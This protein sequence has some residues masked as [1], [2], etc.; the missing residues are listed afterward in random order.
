M[1]SKRQYWLVKSEPE[2]WSWQDQ[3]D[4]GDVGEVWSGVRNHQAANNLKAMKCG[5]R[6]LF[7]HSGKRREIVGITEVIAEAYP[8]PTDESGKFVAV[9]LKAI[10]S[11]AEPLTLADIK[12]DA[13]LSEMPLIR[14]PRLSV[15][16]I[17]ASFWRI[18]M[19][20]IR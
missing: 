11:L 6:V 8:D 7:Y 14:Q 18:L 9:T 10:K 15:M 17:E 16:P 4:R 20:K 19:E 12:S 5:D 13:R 1:P 2:E 3:L